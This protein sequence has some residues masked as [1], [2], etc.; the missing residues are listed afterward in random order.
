MGKGKQKGKWFRFL[1]SMKSGMILLAL[2]AV[3]STLGTL[4]PQGNLQGFYEENYSEAVFRMIRIFQLDDV[5]HSIYFIVLT[6]LLSVNLFYCSIKRLPTAIRQFK[7]SKMFEEDLLK[8]KNIEVKISDHTEPEKLLSELGFRNRKPVL[9]EDKKLWY[10]VR[11]RAG[12]FGSFIVHLGLL[13]VIVAFAAGKIF[14]YETYVR[15]IPGDELFIEET[16][17]HID[18]KD[19]DIQYRS[20]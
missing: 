18:L 12:Y 2:L 3:Y 5:Y 19:F 13:F 20:D 11:R 15:G 10:G 17:Y 1:S 7:K 9:H 14:G 4:L 16:A 6:M 8:R